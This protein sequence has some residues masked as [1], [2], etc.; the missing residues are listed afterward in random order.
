MSPEILKAV[1]KNV[2]KK[3]SENHFLKMI[4]DLVLFAFV[5][6]FESSAIKQFKYSFKKFCLLRSTN[7][8]SVDFLKY[9][10]AYFIKHSDEF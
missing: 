9:H 7:N 10:V 2:E 6:D 4:I 8:F 5:L 1:Y 3:D